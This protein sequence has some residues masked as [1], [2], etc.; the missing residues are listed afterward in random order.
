MIHRRPAVH[1]EGTHLLLEAASKISEKQ[2]HATRDVSPPAITA[3]KKS[4]CFKFLTWLTYMSS[5][6]KIGVDVQN[7]VFL[8]A[9]L[10]HGHKGV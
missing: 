6:Y 3:Y 4:N 1:R 2:E 10:R 5:E 7:F 8:H 9:I